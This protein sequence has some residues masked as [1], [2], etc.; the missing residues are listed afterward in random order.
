MGGYTKL[1]NSIL[2]STVWRENNETRIVWITLLAMADRDGIVEGSVPGLADFARVSVP[3]A[4]A[5]IEKLS[6]PDEYSR[7]LEHEGRRIEPVDGGWRIVNY[8]KYRYRGS[9][10]DAREKAAERKR[11]QRNRE[12]DRRDMSRLSR[13][14][15]T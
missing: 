15:T 4:L 9:A 2:A 12:R 8:E 7:S 11:R 6:A 3:A 5:A 1:F 14:V 10:E 13:N